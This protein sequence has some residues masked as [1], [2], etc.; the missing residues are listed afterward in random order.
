MSTFYVNQRSDGRGGIRPFG[1]FGKEQAGAKVTIGDKQLTV[2]SDGRVNI[3][4]AVFDKYGTDAGNGR[5]TVGITF[6]SSKG[7]EGWK[8]VK[9]GVVEVRGSGKTGQKVQPKNL[10]PNVVIPADSG[11]SS[12]SPV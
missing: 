10:K 1:T 4:K 12:W 9:G 8:D 6:S 3:P 7:K 11:E 5:K 2:T